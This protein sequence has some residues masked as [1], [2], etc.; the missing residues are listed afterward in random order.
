M[1]F[2]LLFL[3]LGCTE[4]IEYGADLSELSSDDAMYYCEARMDWEMHCNDN[5]PNRVFYDDEMESIGHASWSWS[6]WTIRI[7]S[8]WPC[9]RAIF[10]H[11]IGHVIGYNHYDNDWMLPVLT[12]NSLDTNGVELSSYHSHK[13]TDN[14][15]PN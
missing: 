5:G 15:S 7:N 3:I 11:E 6:G 12:C 2:L 10:R 9:R 14:Y 4:E 8:W 1:R 13:S